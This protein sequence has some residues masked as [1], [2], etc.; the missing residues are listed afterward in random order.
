MTHR[1]RI[2]ATLAGVLLLAACSSTPEATDV[3]R[4][5]LTSSE[6]LPSF[7]V[8]ETLLPF[9]FQELPTFDLPFEDTPKSLDGILFGLQEVDGHLEF[10]AVDASGSVLWQTQRPA[11]CSGF[12]LTY[13]GDTPIAVLTDTESTDDSLSAVTASAYDLRTGAPVWGPVEVA[14]PWHGPGTVFAEPAP[15]SAMGEV[16]QRVLLDPATGDPVETSGEVVGEYGGTFL[17]ATTDG[18]SLLIAEGENEWELSVDELTTEDPGADPTITALPGE[19]APDGYALLTVND[20]ETAALIDVTD[21][22]ILTTQATSAGFDDAADLI[23]AAEEHSLGGYGEDGPEWS[24]DL[25]EGLKISA[26][27]GVLTYLRGEDSVQVVNAV[28]GED[29][30]GYAPEATQYAIPVL[31]TA[32]GAGVFSLPEMMLVGTPDE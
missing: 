29:A 25:D 10:S 12:T 5:V 21:G 18:D 4:S 26:T 9:A 32:N 19:D 28:T 3:N 8:D 11:T 16:G 30:V 22:E 7:D 6:Q 15:A 31:V 2:T 1:F 20:A 23:I 13:S 24:R 14:G 17:S 27:G